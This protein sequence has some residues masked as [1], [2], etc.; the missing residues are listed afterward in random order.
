LLSSYSRDYEVWIEYGVQTMHDKTLSY[1]NRGHLYKDFL[2]AVKLTKQYPKLKICAHVIIGLPFETPESI[3]ETAK[4]LGRL[5]LDGIKIHPLHIVKGTKL[6]KLYNDETY[7]PLTLAEY[8]ELASNFIKLLPK[9]TVIQRITADCP[10]NMLAA[11]D[12]ILDKHRAIKEIEK[13]LF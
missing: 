13:H 11:P 5:K 12:W 9:D 10:R 8:A 1:I 2:D 7:K 4:A 6:E 3:T